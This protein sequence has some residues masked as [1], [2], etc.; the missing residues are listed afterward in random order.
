MPPQAN[1]LD[2]LVTAE[3]VASSRLARIG[4]YADNGVGKTTF[5]TTVPGRGLV[6][7]ADQENVKPLKG[8]ADHIRIWK[9]N[10]W[11]DLDDILHLLQ[12]KDTPFEWCA[13]DTWSR[14]QD[15]AINAVVGYELIPI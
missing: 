3:D 14:V 12:G 8:H 6:V 10:D 9:M 7:S 4:L 5:L 13:F 11:N 15:M 1:V 2:R